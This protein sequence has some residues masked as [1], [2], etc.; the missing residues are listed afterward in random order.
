MLS[1]GTRAQT[2]L[3]CVL[4]QQPSDVATGKASKLPEHSIIMHYLHTHM[5]SQ[6]T[7]FLNVCFVLHM[8]F[9]LNNGNCAILTM[10][11]SGQRGCFRLLVL[12]TMI[13]ILFFLSLFLL[14]FLGSSSR[15]ET[16]WR[17]TGSSVCASTAPARSPT[18]GSRW[19]SMAPAVSLHG[20]RVEVGPPLGFFTDWFASC[21]IDL[22]EG[23]AMILV[24]PLAWRGVS[25]C[26]SALCDINVNFL[27][28]AFCIDL[29]RDDTCRQNK[30]KCCMLV[31]INLLPNESAQL[32]LWWLQ[33]SPKWNQ[34]SHS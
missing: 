24:C 11:Q 7:F 27:W 2:S 30:G 17:L 21:V 26:Q 18:A 34:Q 19:R 20:N 29:L 16:G 13:F 15:S 8:Y 32:Y 12:G 28:S 14:R 6:S 5:Y 31:W 3:S 23:N 1:V 25:H 9:T 22:W 33:Q 4:N 10:I